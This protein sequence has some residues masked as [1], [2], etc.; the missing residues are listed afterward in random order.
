MCEN[1]VQFKT[2]EK[3]REDKELLL[4]SGYSLQLRWR[5]INRRLSKKRD[6]YQD[7]AMLEPRKLFDAKMKQESNKS[8][9]FKI[10]RFASVGLKMLREELLAFANFYKHHR[11]NKNNS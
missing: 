4:P 1:N 7:P 6:L 2:G 9:L 5:E 8:L 10:S 3:K 11:S